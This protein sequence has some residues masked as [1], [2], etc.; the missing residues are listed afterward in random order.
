MWIH[1]SLS[2]LLAL[3][4]THPQVYNKEPGSYITSL[5]K[6]SKW[7][8][9]HPLG[10][11]SAKAHQQW[12]DLG[13]RPLLNHTLEQRGV[14]SLS[15]SP[16]LWPWS[17]G[18]E[19]KLRRASQLKTWLCVERELVQFRWICSQQEEAGVAPWALQWPTALLTV[20]PCLALPAMRQALCSDLWIISCYL[21]SAFPVSLLLSA[22][23]WEDEESYLPFSYHTR[24]LKHMHLFA[25]LHKRDRANFLY[26]I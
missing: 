4:G 1:D 9:A 13:L 15:V 19:N 11:K 5:G 10:C 6:P 22:I 24:F 26:W 14:C 2:P 21:S 3:C 8:I 16:E 18:E 7:Q 17:L 12:P 20:L 23:T 25:I